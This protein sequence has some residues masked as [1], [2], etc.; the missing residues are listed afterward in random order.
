MA[1]RITI[2]WTEPAECD[3]KDILGYIRQ[4]SPHAAKTLN[5]KIRHNVSLLN[6]YPEM[7]KSYDLVQPP[8]REIIVLH[9]RIFYDYFPGEKKVQILALFDS[10]QDPAKITHIIQRTLR[11]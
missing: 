9:Y 3:L 6:Q 1:E 10:R 4:K 7:G 11:N 5:T 8:A 2:Q